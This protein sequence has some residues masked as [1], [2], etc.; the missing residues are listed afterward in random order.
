[1]GFL[2]GGPFYHMV[3]KVG[4]N[5]GRI[6]N[7]QNVI[8][9]APAK[10]NRTPTAAQLANQLKFGLVTAWLSEVSQ[11]IRIGFEDHDQ[12]M[13]PWNA[14]V[15]HNILEAV[16][17]VSPSFTIDYPKVLFSQGKLAKGRDMALAITEDAQLDLSWSALVPSL[18]LG[19]PTDKLVVMVYNPAQ[20][21]WVVSVGETTRS[22]LSFDVVLPALWSGDTVYPYVSFVS[23]DSKHASTTQFQGV[24]VVQ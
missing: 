18:F 23:A 14:A 15:R 17:G 8:S 3:G 10:G 20:Q 7:G 19:G 12:D 1:M 2:K 9:M 6:V 24:T 21:D 13:S 5:V 16:T 4:N 22:A 11:F